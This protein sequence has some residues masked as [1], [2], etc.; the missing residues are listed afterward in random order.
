MSKIRSQMIPGILANFAESKTDIFIREDGKAYCLSRGDVTKSGNKKWALL[1]LTRL[2]R[3]LFKRI[4]EP[5]E[6]L[7]IIEHSNPDYSEK[8]KKWV[9]ERL[10][11]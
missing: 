8:L 6:D 7:K 9:Q 3:R 4:L 11:R 5:Q 10:R 1:E 2:N